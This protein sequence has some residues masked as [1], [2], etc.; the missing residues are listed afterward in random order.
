MRFK[1]VLLLL[2]FFWAQ[3]TAFSQKDSL[4]LAGH[5]VMTPPFLP[6]HPL[7]IFSLRLAE[8][9]RMTPPEEPFL[10]ISFSNGNCWSPL[11]TAYI[12]TESAE[13][14]RMRS[15]PWH[16]REK[17]FSEDAAEYQKLMYTADG[18]LRE[19]RLDLGFKV[20]EAHEIG[21]ISRAYYLSAGEAPTALLTSDQFIEWFHSDVYK[22]PDPFARR[23]YGFNQAR[24]RFQDKDGEVLEFKERDV[25]LPATELKYSYYPGW[26]NSRNFA[27]KATSHVAFIHHKYN[28]SLDGGL[29]VTAIKNFSFTDYRSFQI[30][31]SPGVVRRRLIAADDNVDFI[32]AETGIT[33]QGVF[34]YSW[35]SR[36]NGRS[37]LSLG[38]HNQSA[39]YTGDKSYG[40]WALAGERYTS[41]WAVT[42][43]HLFRNL[44][45]WTLAYQHSRKYDITFYIQEDLLVN[46]GPDVQVGFSIGMPLADR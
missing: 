34:R 32:E 16:V 30:G 11:V 33:L 26:L 39:Y 6:T 36:N 46:N 44:Q 25:F 45:A 40:Y 37:T 35:L 14:E 20:K 27:L 7:G 10:N 38:M 13:I 1:F 43:H 8:D 24:I 23:I 4:K 28:T 42:F 3:L 18:V 22:D 2:F 9:F 31:C 41:H 12:P 5:Q 29:A 19:L 17:S 21:I 15:L